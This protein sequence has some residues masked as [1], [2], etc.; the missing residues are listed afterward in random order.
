MLGQDGEDPRWRRL[1]DHTWDCASCGTQHRGLF[2][3]SSAR[4]EAWPDGEEWRPNLEVIESSHVLAEDFCI[5]NGEHFFVRCLLLLPIRGVGADAIFGFGIW[6]T[7]SKKN[8]ELYVDTFDSGD[9][10]NL[11]PWFGWLSNRLHGYPDTLNLKCQIHPR[12]N[13]QRPFVE[14]ESVDHP[15]AIEQRDGITLDRLLDIYAENGHDVRA[16]LLD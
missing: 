15:L 11:G 7:L 13:R 12:A 10:G 4:P 8:F 9:Q 6:S 5:L 16:A 1:N 2:D 3:L 14:L